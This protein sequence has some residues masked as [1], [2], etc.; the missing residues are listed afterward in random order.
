MISFTP[1]LLWHR[2]ISL[3][4]RMIGHQFPSES[5][6]EE[7]MLLLLLIEPRFLGR[8]ATAQSLYRLN[9]N[10]SIALEGNAEIKFP[11]NTEAMKLEKL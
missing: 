4:H 9:Y 10:S 5:V 8:P 2:E 11:L 7:K 3:K 6:G 1:P